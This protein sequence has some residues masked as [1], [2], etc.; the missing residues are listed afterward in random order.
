[1]DRGNRLPLDTFSPFG[2]FDA[3]GNS[4]TDSLIALRE[5]ARTL[6]SNQHSDAAITEILDLTGSVTITRH[7]NHRCWHKMCNSS[8][9][10]HPGPNQL[11]RSN[12]VQILA[13]VVGCVKR[14]ATHHC[15]SACNH[16]ALRFA[17]RTLQESQNHRLASCGSFAFL[18]CRDCDSG[19]ESA[20]IRDA[21]TVGLPPCFDSLA[22]R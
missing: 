22:S 21:T 5:T 18:R 17:S 19:I 1:M 11:K 2:V 15:G 3:G 14:S 4:D 13:A 20:T 8:L 10:M 12:A 9:T 16:G 7:S 6:I